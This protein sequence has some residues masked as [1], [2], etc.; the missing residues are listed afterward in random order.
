M[1]IY[2]CIKINKIILQSKEMV[3]VYNSFAV[4]FEKDCVCIVNIGNQM[5]YLCK[6]NTIISRIHSLTF[7]V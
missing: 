1:Y 3:I 2:I 6:K 7:Y 5:L 4:T